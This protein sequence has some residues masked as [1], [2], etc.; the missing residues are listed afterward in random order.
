MTCFSYEDFQNYFE[1][2][3]IKKSNVASAFEM[4]VKNTLTVCNTNAAF[5]I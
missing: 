4:G 1:K 3:N 2:P 5:V